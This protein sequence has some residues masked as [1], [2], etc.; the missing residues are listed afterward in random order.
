MNDQQK[1]LD[2]VADRL[3]SSL[4]ELLELIS[5][6][7]ISTEPEAAADIRH[8]AEWLKEKLDSIGFTARVIETEGHPVVLGRSELHEQGGPR[9]LFYG[10]YDVQPVGDIKAWQHPPF[11]PSVQEED[12]FHR[13]YGRGSSDSKSQLWT[14]IEALRCW[15]E[16]TGAFPG[17]III[18][19]EG[20]EE[21]GSASLPAFIGDHLL[22]LQCDVAFI[23]DAE[24]WSRTQPA[25]TT[26]LKG[27]VHEK[28]TVL[29]QNPDLHSGHYGAV[30]AN[31]IRILSN[32]LSGLHDADGKISI[33]GFYDNVETLPEETRRQWAEL[34][35]DRFAVG[36]VK[37]QGGVVEAGYSLLEA[38]WGR[39][40]IDMNGVTSG[41]QGPGER[42][43][44][45]ASATARLSFRLVPGQS[46]EEVRDKFRAHITSRLPVGCTVEFE[47]NGGSGAVRLS[48]N[49]RFL[50]A[51][52]RG[53]ERE[54]S[55]PTVLRGTGGAIPLVG[56]LSD[57]LKADCVVIGFILPSDAIH[58]PDENYDLERLS[59]GI[60]SWI[61]IFDE[62]QQ[63]K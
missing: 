42:S 58:A 46:P 43:V 59:R 16:T 32:I 7:S 34:S 61:C 39:P 31:P 18:L 60:R 56:L 21:S 49:S 10:H 36:E 6:P 19:L 20:E 48:Q 15:K 44:L 13:F 57:A 5:I 27:L 55:T 30:A 53:L 47:G 40:T 41:N 33:D 24:M 62:L 50:Q 11:E 63:T 45:P 1:V 28:V 4:A 3:G 23:C 26:Q 14:F 9:M 2:R 51:A 38:M 35:R 29:T 37:L 52:S 22:E 17:E 25:I 8:A 12:G 54:W